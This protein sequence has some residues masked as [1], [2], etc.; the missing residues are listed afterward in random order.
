MKYKSKKF[1]D[2][3]FS[4]NLKIYKRVTFFHFSKP[5]FFRKKKKKKKRK[6]FSFPLYQDQKRIA[7]Y[8]S[9]YKNI[10]ICMYVC[11]YICSYVR[12][13]MNQ[14]TQRVRDVL[15]RDDSVGTIR[16]WATFGQ[17]ERVPRARSQKRTGPDLGKFFTDRSTRSRDSNGEEERRWEAKVVRTA[18]VTGRKTS[19]MNSLKKKKKR[20][21]NSGNKNRVRT[22]GNI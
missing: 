6:W 4:G 10:H 3:N 20:C 14:H 2:C 16:D 7:E 15:R 17:P 18:I 11:M 9:I 19:K 21:R 13:Y 1:R 8:I 12:T 5:R 22:R